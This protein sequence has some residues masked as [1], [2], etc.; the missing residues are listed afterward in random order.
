M[1]IMKAKAREV[2][3]G[4]EKEWEKEGVQRIVDMQMT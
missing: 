4:K 1:Q 3:D 2:T